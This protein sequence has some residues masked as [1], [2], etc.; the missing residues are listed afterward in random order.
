VNAFAEYKF[1][2]NWAE[3]TTIDDPSGNPGSNPSGLNAYY[4]KGSTID[5]REGD[6]I[7]LKFELENI[8][9]NDSGGP[10]PVVDFEVEIQTWRISFPYINFEYKWNNPSNPYTNATGV[11]GYGQKIVFTVPIEVNQLSNTTDFYEVKDIDITIKSF[12]NGAGGP[13]YALDDLSVPG[14]NSPNARFYDPTYVPPPPAPAN[15]KAYLD[16]ITCFS[17]SGVQATG[18]GTSSNPIRCD[19][20]D[21]NTITYEIMIEDI[22][23]NHNSST[24]HYVEIDFFSLDCL[25]YPAA[26]RTMHW[27]DGYPP[28]GIQ[29]EGF[30]AAC[31]F[32]HYNESSG[33]QPMHYDCKIYSSLTG[34]EEYARP[35]DFSVPIPEC[36]DYPASCP[37]QD[38]NIFYNV[39]GIH[40]TRKYLDPAEFTLQYGDQKIFKGTLT[41]ARTGGNFRCYGD[42]RYTVRDASGTQLYSDQEPLIVDGSNQ[43]LYDGTNYTFYYSRYLK[44]KGHEAYIVKDTGQFMP[45]SPFVRPLV[46][47]TV[48]IPIKN[49][50]DPWNGATSKDILYVD[51]NIISGSWQI[52]TQ[53]LEIDGSDAD[54]TLN[55]DEE[56]LFFVDF[57]INEG[58]YHQ[59]LEAAAMKAMLYDENKWIYD[60]SNEIPIANVRLI[61]ILNPLIYAQQ[62]DDCF[63]DP[64]WESLCWWNFLPYTLSPVDL[65][66]NQDIEFILRLRNPFD[67]NEFFDLTY[68]TNDPAN[69]RLEFEP[70]RNFIPPFTS[71]EFGYK[72]AKM[73][74]RNPRI[75]H[76]DSNYNVITT[77]VNHP[78]VWDNLEVEFKNFSHNL[79][80]ESF[81][82]IP[83]KEEYSVGEPLS[84][85]LAVKNTGDIIERDINFLVVSSMDPTIRFYAPDNTDINPGE[86]LIF[87]GSLPVIPSRNVFVVEATLEKVPFEFDLSDNHELIVLR[88]KYEGDISTLSELNY[89]FVVFVVLAI[90]FVVRKK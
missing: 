20:V 87:T 24:G 62:G 33:I 77:S 39:N 13:Q 58:L 41:F 30:P 25:T 81:T 61:T 51:V 3:I 63:T 86:T 84:F 38:K 15:I 32:L 45:S 56:K 42:V 52:A 43:G 1:Q 49:T 82:V 73:I 21:S 10:R 19:Q 69:A 88:T 37:D 89:L 36:P 29:Y 12:E 78:Y 64:A 54:H 67:F 44:L 75:I 16:P 35:P 4:D 26:F 59:F 7:E 71:G 17:S 79:K 22:N 27:N 31:E 90:L 53:T 48:E 11:F 80:I 50:G 18:T 60:L 23:G 40:F 2:L 57:P 68:E 14:T 72:Y 85:E 70:Q 55:T 6:W 46:P 34:F 83:Q 76:G 5:L 9:T 8:S 47:W 66:A 65:N 28:M 74:L